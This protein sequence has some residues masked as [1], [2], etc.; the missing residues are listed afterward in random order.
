MAVWVLEVSLCMS[1]DA[2][3]RQG[4]EQELLCCSGDP[5]L[6][7]QLLFT[8]CRRSEHSTALMTSVG[9]VWQINA[10]EVV[11]CRETKLEHN[12]II[13]QF[14]HHELN[15]DAAAFGTAFTPTLWSLWIWSSVL[16]FESPHF[17]LLNLT[18]PTFVM[19]A[20]PY[21]QKKRRSL[22]GFVFYL[23]LWRTFAWWINQD[24]E[25]QFL[26][27]DLENSLTI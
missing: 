20:W 9:I 23:Q 12:H 11:H 1:A 8:R 5:S 10:R 2:D 26:D 17:T 22:F 25:E 16:F 13:F 3:V 27:C 15:P 18:V 4:A 7:Q 6:I 14:T 19:A 21:A 24:G